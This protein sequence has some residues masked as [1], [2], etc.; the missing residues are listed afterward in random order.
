MMTVR[1][2]LQQ[3]HDTSKFFSTFTFPESISNEEKE[4]AAC[5]K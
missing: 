1:A 4:A 3:E 2:S 5:K